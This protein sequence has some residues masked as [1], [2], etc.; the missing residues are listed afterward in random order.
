MDLDQDPRQSEGQNK[1]WLLVVSE[2]YVTWVFISN[3]N[4]VT[5]FGY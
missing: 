5:L 3:F 4:C 1:L 2:Q